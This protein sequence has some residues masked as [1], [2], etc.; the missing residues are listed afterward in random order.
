MSPLR[1]FPRTIRAEFL[2]RPNRFLVS[3]RLDGKVV[4]AF[5]PNPGR[6]RELLLPGARLHLIEEQDAFG[7][8][9][10]LTVVAVERDGC[11]IMLHTQRTNDVARFLLEQGKIPGL[12][13]VE[14]RKPEVRIGRSRFDFLLRKGSEEIILEVK[15]CTLFGQNVAMF[16]DAVTVRG[17][18]HLLELASLSDKGMKTAVLFVVQWPFATLFAPDYHT[19]LEF[20]R[21]LLQVRQR[22]QIIP[23]SVQWEEDLTLS[24]DVRSL[25]IP[26]TYVEREAQ[27]RGSYILVLRL[28]RRRK[29]AIGRLGTIAFPKGFYLYVG[30]AMARLT[31]R[32]QRHLRTE[33]KDHWHIDFLRAVA[34]SCYALPIRSSHRLE[35]ELAEALKKI[36]DWGVCGFG[37]TDC[38]CETHLFGMER[39]PLQSKDF[40]QLLQYFRMDR[41]FNE[42]PVL[43]RSLPSAPALSEA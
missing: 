16:P 2:T 10:P 33:K 6:L 5:L 15:S 40:H 24:S 39:D 21:T 31:A 36:A 26:W 8:K 38:S 29:V 14:I 1:L 37:S 17:R 23:V 35:C 30:S 43:S 7:R 34:E 19:D 13:A 28:V 22:V 42:D 4:H 32:L 9:N 11:P 18:R 27:D 20:S 25:R 41:I 12:G 3:C